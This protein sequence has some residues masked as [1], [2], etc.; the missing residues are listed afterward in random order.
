VNIHHSNAQVRLPNE[1]RCLKH[2]LMKCYLCMPKPAEPA[3]V[4]EP[5]PALIVAE[6]AVTPV[7]PA[8]TNEVILVEPEK[9]TF[10]K[11]R[12]EMQRK[13]R[14][15]LYTAAKDTQ[16]ENCTADLLP[17][18]PT[19]FKTFPNW[20]T[21]KDATKE[22]KAP[23]I[24]GTFI[25][26]SSGDP[27]TWV[28]YE[29]ACQNITQE[30]GYRNLGFVTDGERA[31]NLMGVDIDGCI[32]VRAN[33]VTP[34][35]KEILTFLGP[36]YVEIT[37]SGT[38][39]RAWIIGSIPKGSNVFK[40]RLD[41]GWGDKV[42]VEVYDDRKYFTMSGNTYGDSP[43]V[44]TPLKDVEGL[45]ALLH[46]IQERFPVETKE[47]AKRKT[48]SKRTVAQEKPGGGVLFVAAEPDPAFKELFEEVGWTPLEKRMDAMDDER[49][50]G[51]ELEEGK[52]YYCPMP[53][54]Q[55]C[56]TDLAYTKCFGPIKGN[57]AVVSCFGCQWSGDLV[58]TVKEFD[59]GE[60]GGQK[61]YKNAYEC[62]R[63]ICVE[64]GL[65]VDKWF[66]P[67]VKVEAKEPTA[68]VQEPRT[69]T[70][71]GAGVATA[72]AEDNEEHVEFESFANIEGVLQ[73]WLWP[74][75]IPVGALTLFAG[76][77]DVGKTI[78]ALDV[79]ARVTKGMDFPNDAK[80]DFPPSDVI[81]LEAEDD[82]EKTLWPRLMVAAEDAGADMPRVSDVKVRVKGTTKRMRMLQ[83]D[84][85]IHHIEAGLRAHPDCRLV[86]ISPI[87]AYLGPNVKAIDDGAIRAILTPLQ[88]MAARQ[89][90][91]VVAIMHLNKAAD[92]DVLYRISGAMGFVAVA[93]ATWLFAK[94]AREKGSERRFMMPVKGNLAE[95][96]KGLEYQIIL[97][98]KVVKVKDKRKGVIVETFHPRIEW[99]ETTMLDPNEVM[100]EEAPTGGGRSGDKL[101]AAMA[102]LETL[103][104]DPAT[105]KWRS[106]PVPLR[107]YS[108]AVAQAIMKMG[109][110]ARTLERAQKRLGIYYDRKTQEYAMT[111]P[112]PDGQEVVDV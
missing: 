43:S 108:K 34:W 56:S 74:G 73:E 39:L 46:Q 10:G 62:G 98:D 81:L 64:E 102:Y 65:S 6:P 42:Q 26:A 55:P 68:M 93:R 7:T 110:P 60:D 86:V 45:I 103:F 11:L 91:A 44:V 52:L 71:A 25:N 70:A 72:V 9:L 63:A 66:P 22:G 21:H 33:E 57:P 75:H 24:S 29:A 18:V 27:T 109:L 67:R 5:A 51:I 80:N 105:G 47:S 106:N 69:T 82:K 12:G 96:Q 38:G 20:V 49:F 83:L 35:A 59:S 54:H 97:S 61:E 107:T 30:K 90:V 8:I 79:I 101:P 41:A 95:K 99:G 85:D 28:T 76:N 31:G 50:S 112:G 48:R 3:A 13:R 36:T 111:D 2:N 94:D 37:P 92:K 16:K 78:A 104:D 77:P 1:P 23:I 40:L 100:Q 89:N 15:R 87:S 84:K 58:S 4:V 19:I 17:A 14:E 32:N 53:G 88:D